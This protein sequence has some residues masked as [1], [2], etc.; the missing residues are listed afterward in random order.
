MKFL[1]QSL[2]LFFAFSN[3]VEAAIYNK[4]FQVVSIRANGQI[5]PNKFKKTLSVKQSW[6]NTYPSKQTQE[7]FGHGGCNTYSAQVSFA[8]LQQSQFLVPITVGPIRSSLIACQAN[9]EE[10]K[11]LKLLQNTTSIKYEGSTERIKLGS[12]NATII[13][14]AIATQ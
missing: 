8:D 10:T 11:Y 5:L 12:A 7:I 6:S 9:L 13:L 1:L 2:I 4:E 3:I 14:K